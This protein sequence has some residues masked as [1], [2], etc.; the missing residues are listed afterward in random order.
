[1]DVSVL[2]CGALIPSPC[3]A[4]NECRIRV[5]FREKAVLPETPA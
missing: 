1:M 2:S 4:G 3:I 5:A